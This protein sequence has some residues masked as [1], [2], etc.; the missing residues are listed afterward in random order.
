MVLMEVGPVG[1]IYHE[2]G[3]LCFVKHLACVFVPFE[4]ETGGLA[5]GYKAKEASP[6]GTPLL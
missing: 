2:G 5:H 1:H 4:L 3:R 6:D